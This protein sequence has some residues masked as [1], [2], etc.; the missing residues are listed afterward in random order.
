MKVAVVTPLLKKPS[1][2]CDIL[3]NYRP[4]S[5][6]SMVS[7]LL[8]KVVSTR[9][10]EHCNVNGIVNTYQSAYK[11]VH[12]TETALLRVQNDLLR[13]VDSQGGAILVLLDLSA[14]FDTIDHVLLV[15]TLKNLFGVDGA[16]LRWFQ[17]YLDSRYQRVKIGSVVSSDKHLQYG[18]PQ[19]SV[20]GPQLFTMYT[21]PLAS[22]IQH[23]GMDFHL[24]ADDTQI[25]ISFNPK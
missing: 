25:Y 8:E 3:G 19:G 1:L 20:L 2:D 4:V 15:Q 21:Q 17:S 6:L 16:A 7:K 5:N 23:I 9:I 22:V 10:S 14:A 18:V 12:S 13:A 24:Y 11:K